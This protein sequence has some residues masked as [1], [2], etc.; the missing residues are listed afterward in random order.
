MSINPLKT[1]FPWIYY[2][3]VNVVEVDQIFLI[4][5]RI[6]GFESLEILPILSAGIFSFR[7]NLIVACTSQEEYDELFVDLT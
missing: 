3:F 1:V 7:A 6:L 4:F 2:A 5:D